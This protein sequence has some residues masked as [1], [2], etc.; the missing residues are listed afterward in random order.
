VSARDNK[1][2][3]GKRLSSGALFAANAAKNR[4]FR[5]NLLAAPKGFPLQSLA[6]RSERICGMQIRDQPLASH[7]LF[8]LPRGLNLLK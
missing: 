4:T 1:F 7:G 2:L 5:Y 3:L 6:P 8:A